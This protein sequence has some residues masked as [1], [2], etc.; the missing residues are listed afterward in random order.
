MD[1]HQAR[2]P[3]WHAH[4][5][6]DLG[7]FVVVTVR[8]VNP[9]SSRQGTHA[10]GG[11]GRK[12]KGGSLVDAVKTGVR[13]AF[14][15]NPDLASR[16][17]EFMAHKKKY[18]FRRNPGELKDLVPHALGGAAGIVVSRSTTR[19]VLG[20][21]GTVLSAFGEGAIGLVGGWALG[22]FGAP[23]FGL[24]FGIG[25]VA[26]GAVDLISSI[27]GLNLGLGVYAPYQF[28]VPPMLT[29]QGLLSSGTTVVATAA[30]R[31]SGPGSAMHAAMNGGGMRS[32]P[33]GAPR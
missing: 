15:E 19:M 12:R 33:R 4:W 30:G 9:G 3:D 6:F 13:Q 20:S 29:G 10:S 5:I 16:G 28:A 26:I 31:P 22:K 32:A 11:S 27:F 2:G 18:F 7:E 8:L 17:G 1:A 23:R 21:K 14:A 25:G 24:G